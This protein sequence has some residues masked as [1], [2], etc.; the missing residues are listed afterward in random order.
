[1]YYHFYRIASYFIMPFLPF[2]LRWRVKQGKEEPLR[3][4]ERFGKASLPRPDTPLIWVHAA[5]M[6][7]SQSV[8]PLVRRWAEAFPQVHILM[9]TVTVTSAR[10]VVTRLPENAFH[11]FAPLDTP[12]AIRRFLKHWQP[13][14]ACFVDSELWPNMIVT[15][16]AFG[17]PL[18]LLNGRISDSS[19]QRWH[20][21]RAFSEQLL[22]CFTHIFAKSDEDTRRFANLGAVNPVS[23]GNMKFS[24]PPLPSDSKLMGELIGEIGGRPVWLAASTHE[25]EEIMIGEIH[26]HLQEAFP[27]LLSIIVP[28]HNTRGDTIREA[29]EMQELRV[30]QRSRKETIK[31]HTD[32]YIADTMGELGIFYRMASIVFIGGS[33]VPHGG[34]NP[35]EAARLDCAILYGAHMDNFREFCTELEQAGAAIPVRDQSHL[36]ESLETLLRDQGKQDEMAQAALDVVE[37]NKHVIDHIH[38]AL[39]PTILHAI[40]TYQTSDESA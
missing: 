4:K 25:G 28:R 10:H 20:K 23:F 32:V 1:M 24:S 39:S 12:L 14:M 7:E 22:Q 30:V 6:G 16:H 2:Y 40:E 35:L 37:R 18:A 27:G 21:V 11:Q 17:I 31:A 5:S 9:T 34:Q 13:D 36:R 19:A 15:I 8:M 26:S 38:E 29:L 3:M 33:L